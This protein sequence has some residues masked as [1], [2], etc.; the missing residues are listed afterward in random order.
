MD[1]GAPVNVDGNYKPARVIAMA[2]LDNPEIF[3]PSCERLAATAVMS[4]PG[5]VIKNGYAIIPP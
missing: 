3:G 5:P 2:N 4:L 1:S